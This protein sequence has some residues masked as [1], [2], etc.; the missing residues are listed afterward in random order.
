MVGSFANAT[1]TGTYYG[2]TIVS[3]SAIISAA[4]SLTISGSVA[5]TA[6]MTFANN[7]SISALGTLNLQ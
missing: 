7:S 1:L 3:G 5:S 6:N 4:G 2:Q